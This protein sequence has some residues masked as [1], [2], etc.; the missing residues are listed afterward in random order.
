V[1]AAGVLLAAS[2]GSSDSGSPGTSPPTTPAPTVA[3]TV[4]PTLPVPASVPTA[5]ELAAVKVVE[6]VMYG[7]QLAGAWP[8]LLDVYAPAGAA[9]LPL[10]V[11]FHGGGVNKQS[12]EYPALARSIA[13]RGAVV[14]VPSWGPQSGDPGALDA[15]AEAAETVGYMDGAACSVSYA[16]THAAEWGAST[17][18]DVVLMGHS[19]GANAASVLAF[20]AGRDVGSCGVPATAWTPVGAVL[21]EG[22]LGLLDPSMWDRFG[23]DLTKI[24]GALTPWG[25]L[26]S[27]FVGPVV[28]VSS[29]QSRGVLRRCDT[30]DTWAPLRDPTGAY[31]GYLTA[32]GAPNDGCVD[33][34]EVEVAL[35][36]AM[37]DAGVQNSYVELVDASTSHTIWSADDVQRLAQLAFELT[38]A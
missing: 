34:G 16:V 26:D 19:G 2:C 30:A 9:D 20:S 5:E 12:L 38:R 24:F 7:E 28:L 6:D 22:E 33:I 1:F 3:A 27:G 29:Q 11:F 31:L 36:L 13:A 35:G 21:W 15:T 4:A 23:P 18:G 37:T 32:A 10:L 17:S 25:M 14:V 8:P